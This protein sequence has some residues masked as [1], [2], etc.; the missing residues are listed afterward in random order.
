[1][2]PGCTQNDYWWSWVV[3]SKDHKVIASCSGS[4]TP[5][6]GVN[7]EFSFH[8]RCNPCGSGQRVILAIEDSLSSAAHLRRRPMSLLQFGESSYIAVR[9]NSVRRYLLINNSVRQ[10]IK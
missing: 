10:Q 8:L 5:D 4:Q 9:N 3:L 1:M 2:V 7:A 6:L